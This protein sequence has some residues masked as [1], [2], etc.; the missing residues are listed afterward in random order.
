[1]PEVVKANDRETIGCQ[2]P[3]EVMGYKVRVNGYAVWLAT[4]IPWAVALL[5]LTRCYFAVTIH[6]PP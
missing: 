3:L 4:A 2:Y 1:M 6:R 5:F